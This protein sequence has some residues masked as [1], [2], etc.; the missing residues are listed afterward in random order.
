MGPPMGR[1]EIEI[2]EPGLPLDCHGP[3]PGEAGRGPAWR[4]R[5][6]VA[7]EE[8]GSGEGLRTVPRLADQ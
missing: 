4:D 1:H 3:D 6:A 7:D 8:L 5:I 2:G